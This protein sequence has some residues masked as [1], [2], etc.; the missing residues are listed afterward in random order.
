VFIV[1]LVCFFRIEQVGRCGTGVGSH[2]RLDLWVVQEIRYVCYISVLSVPITEPT[3]FCYNTRPHLLLGLVQRHLYK[4]FHESW[5]TG[6][7]CGTA[8][9]R[10]WS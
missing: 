9:L 2:L 10:V 3:A 7:L 1:F 8:I 5:F 4:G 6:S